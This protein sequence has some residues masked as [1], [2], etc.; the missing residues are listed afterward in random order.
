MKKFLG[1]TAL[2]A[3]FTACMLLMMTR[4]AKAYVDP[5]TTTFIIQAVSGV[6]IAVGAFLVIHFRRAK[7]KV[8]WFMIFAAKKMPK[9]CGCQRW[10]LMAN[11]TRGQRGGRYL[12][13]TAL[14]PIRFPST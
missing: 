6:A 13:R 3:Y 11:I 7:K 5:T 8:D 2:L 10:C 1:K 14:I 12:K 4:S 9:T